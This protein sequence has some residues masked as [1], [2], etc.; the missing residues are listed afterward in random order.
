MGKRALLLHLSLYVIWSE[1]MRGGGSFF[2]FARQGFQT[3]MHTPI[4][5]EETHSFQER[6]SE[7]Y[8]RLQS[9]S[10]ASQEPGRMGEVGLA[11]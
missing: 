3:F 11:W 9:T 8:A 10:T 5:G 7:H 6:P 4:D 1:I 2:D